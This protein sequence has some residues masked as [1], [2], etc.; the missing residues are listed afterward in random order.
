MY[1]NH[2]NYFPEGVSVQQDPSLETGQEDQ[3]RGHQGDLCTEMQGPVQLWPL[4]VEGE[5]RHPKKSSFREF[6]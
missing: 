5:R 2:W 6:L 1:Q 4:Q 3:E